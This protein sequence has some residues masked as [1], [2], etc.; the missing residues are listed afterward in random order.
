MSHPTCGRPSTTAAPG[1][2]VQWA[3]DLHGEE[4][5]VRYIAWHAQEILVAVWH[6]PG[7]TV[8][9]PRSTS[10][11]CVYAK[12]GVANRT[13]LAGLAARRTSNGA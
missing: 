3:T 8:P 6:W 12:L 13:E 4:P 7:T 1:R 11:C 9:R 2:P 5:E 10:S